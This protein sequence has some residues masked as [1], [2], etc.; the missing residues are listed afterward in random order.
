[1]IILSIKI[2]LYRFN[3]IRKPNIISINVAKKNIMQPF[4]I[5]RD[6]NLKC[7]NTVT[8]L[9]YIYIFIHIYIRICGYIFIC[10]HLNICL[11]I[12]KVTL[13]TEALDTYTR[14]VTFP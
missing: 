4:S 8:Y 11:Q 13:N 10:I 12:N 6:N 5:M 2:Y 1:M 3:Y 9:V 7:L 14:H